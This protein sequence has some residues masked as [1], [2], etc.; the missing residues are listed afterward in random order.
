LPLV[1]KLAGLAHTFIFELPAEL[2]TE[3]SQ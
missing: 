3:Q 2:N 1:A